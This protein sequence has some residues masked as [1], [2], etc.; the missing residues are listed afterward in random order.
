MIVGLTSYPKVKTVKLPNRLG[1]AFYKK[2]TYDVARSNM[3]LPTKVFLH[4]KAATYADM[5]KQG[6]DKRPI[7]SQIAER[8]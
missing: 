7:E 5:P 1:S 4:K 3:Q 8:A 6:N 2:K